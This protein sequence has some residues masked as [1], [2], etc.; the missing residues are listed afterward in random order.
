M[1]F[2]GYTDNEGVHIFSSILLEQNMIDKLINDLKE[3][4]NIQ[5]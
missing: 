2:I 1:D 3:I 4:K 5:K